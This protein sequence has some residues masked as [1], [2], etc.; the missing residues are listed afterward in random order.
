MAP[1]A[2]VATSK[3]GQKK[4][5][6]TIRQRLLTI[7]EKGFNTAN[8]FKDDQFEPNLIVRSENGTVDVVFSA[9][10]ITVMSLF[11]L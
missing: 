10:Y 8:P 6:S 4:V 1:I 5:S 11:S 2:P 3:Q 7:A 9:L